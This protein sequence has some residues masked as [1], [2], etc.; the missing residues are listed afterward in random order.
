MVEYF[1]QFDPVLIKD[2]QTER[3]TMDTIFHKLVSDGNPLYRWYYGHFHQSWN[4]EISGVQFKMLDIMEFAT[5]A[6]E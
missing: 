5:I 1:A 4:A 3:E 6:A 2:V